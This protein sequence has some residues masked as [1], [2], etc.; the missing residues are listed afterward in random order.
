MRYYIETDGR[1]FLVRRNG[2]LDLPK[3]DEVPF[4]IERI[5]PLGK[6]KDV[7]FCVPHLPSHPFSWPGKDEMPER[8]DVSPAVRAA[9]HASMPRVVVEGIA[10]EEDSILLVKSSRGLTAGLWS[11]PGGFLEFGENPEDGLAREIKEE[12]NTGAE[13]DGLVS[14]RAKVGRSSGLHWIMLFYRVR[15][16]GEPIPAPDEIEEARLVPI[17]QGVNLLC[18]ATMAGVV[19]T[20]DRATD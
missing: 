6:E 15:L 16:L 14:V 10:I 7:W 12:L 19:A 2:Y 4:P 8:T 17:S 9:V 3:P 13:I 18:D 20:L 11:L 1:I 5:A